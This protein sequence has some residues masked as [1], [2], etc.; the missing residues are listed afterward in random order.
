M[1]VILLYPY[2][3]E[4]MLYAVTSLQVAWFI[5]WWAGVRRFVNLSLLSVAGD[6]LPF[7]VIALV[8]TISA[9]FMSQGISNNLLRLMVKVVLAAGHYWVWM[10]VLKPSVYKESVA[11]FCNKFKK[12]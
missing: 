4:R 2:G 1:C 11:F 10:L 7:F 9:H 6:V 5:V 12:K 8:T 3:V